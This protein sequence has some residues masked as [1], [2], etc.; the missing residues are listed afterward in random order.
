MPCSV[1]CL[2]PTPDQVQPLIDRL[3]DAGVASRDIMVVT[4]EEAPAA[5]SSPGAA[6]SQ[7]WSMPMSPAALWWM[8][9]YGWSAVLPATRRPTRSAEP[10]E[11]EVEVISLARYRAGRGAGR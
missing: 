5:S 7:W 8:S 6:P 9:L 3:K 1:Y 4:R 2:V 11:H 10:G